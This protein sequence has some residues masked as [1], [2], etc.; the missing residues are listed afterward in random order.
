MKTC[1]TYS[2]YTIHIQKRIPPCDECKKASRDYQRNKRKQK[3]SDLGYDPRRFSRHKITKEFYEDLL[4]KYLGKCWIC[5]DLAATNI[6]HDHN[7]CS[8]SYSC[9]KCVRGILCNNCNTAIGLLK[10][11][12]STLKS[13]IDYLTK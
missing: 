10:D 8:G 6:D 1:G 5:K 13:A 7:C 11:E 12:L 3:V 2:G 4:S 9:G